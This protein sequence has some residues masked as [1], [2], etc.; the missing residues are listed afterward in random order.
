MNDSKEEIELK[1]K[2]ANIKNKKFFEKVK[3][4]ILNVEKYIDLASEGMK[5]AV[6]YFLRLVLILAFVMVISILNDMYQEFEKGKE[7]LQD[8]FPDFVYTEGKL[9]VE[10]QETLRISEFDSFFGN[11]VV[12]T[13]PDKQQEIENEILNEEI[14]VN[15]IYVLQDKIVIK[16]TLTKN[17]LTYEYITIA[18]TLQFESLDKESAIKYLESNKVLLIYFALFIILFIYTSCLYVIITLSNVL[19]LSLIGYITSIFAKIR[20]RY[21]AIF[22]M[23]IYALTLSIIL[24]IIYI[25]VNI[26]VDFEIEYF[27]VM[28][29][30]VSSIYLI[31]AIFILKME[32]IKRQAELIELSEEKKAKKYQ[33]EIEKSLLEQE[34]KRQEKKKKKEKEKLDSNEKELE[35]E[36][37]SDEEKMKNGAV[38]ES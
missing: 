27:Q 32:I 15:T 1:E 5:K 2:T 19:F 34:Q 8:E 4:S 21:I 26:F 24:N 30:A 28:Y 37:I 29:T 20:M 14:N 38:E 22:N 17:T 23:A 13:N 12:N 16:D 18:E 25:G 31:A 7:Y 9:D 6:T 36:E 3:Y 11:I 35:D 10:T 33:E